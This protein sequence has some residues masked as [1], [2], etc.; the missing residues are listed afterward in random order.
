LQVCRNHEPHSLR[1]P[2]RMAELQ[3]YEERE[4]KSNDLLLESIR[5]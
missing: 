2:E 5:V 1:V 3:T 4:P